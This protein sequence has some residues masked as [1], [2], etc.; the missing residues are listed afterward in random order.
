MDEILEILE[1]DA[2]ADVADRKTADVADKICA[3]GGIICVICGCNGRRKQ[4]MRY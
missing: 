2:T 4:W 1:K 3:I